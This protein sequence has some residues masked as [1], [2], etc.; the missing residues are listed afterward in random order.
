MSMLRWGLCTVQKAMVGAEMDLTNCQ[1]AA[2]VTPPWYS[3]AICAS[4][5]SVSST[6]FADIIR[7][8]LLHTATC[9]HTANKSLALIQVKYFSCH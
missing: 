7:D 8:E 4:D 6:S 1:P 5:F 2:A 9:E 3:E